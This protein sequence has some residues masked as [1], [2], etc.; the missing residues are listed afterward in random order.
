MSSNGL[1]SLDYYSEH[2]AEMCRRYDDALERSGRTALV[3]GAGRPHGIF[4]D[5]QH[6]PYKANPY[7]LQWGPLSE[8]PGSALLVQ[9]GKT[10]R[11]LVHAPVDYWH[12]I[13]PVPEL[14]MQSG[15]EI[16]SLSSREEITKSLAG[17]IR[18]SSATTAFIGETLSADDSFGIEAVNPP[19]L[20]EIL[21]EYRTIKTPWEI[22]NLK[23][24]S[25]IGVQGHLAAEQCFRG[26]GSEYEIQL[27]F[28]AACNAT[29]DEMPYPAIVA[30]NE[31]AATLHYQRLDRVR[32]QNLSLLID[33][34]HAVNGYAAD[35]TRSHSDDAE[36]G[37]LIEAMHELQR[38]LCD[39]AL[40]SV[41]YRELHHAAHLAITALLIEIGVINATLEAAHEAGLSRSFFP[42]GLGHFL[43]LNVHDVGALYTR[44]QPGEKV[45]PDED[46]HLRL[47]RTLAP[48]NVLTIEPGIYFIDSLLANLKQK[49]ASA[50]INWPRVDQLRPYG[51]IRIED[52][53]Y[54]TTDGNENL[55]RRAFASFA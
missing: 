21:N 37:S 33:A 35:I 12:R 45:R 31:H 10:P 3:I 24:A 43:G 16:I 26:G 27:A 30:L 28:R 53:L 39:A 47:T 52:N 38:G 15:L 22:A 5:D 18:G 17:A 40:P 32:E 46:K 50:M 9:P 11:L 25:A 51:G 55:T 8:H 36:F 19:E 42:H 54:I 4:L 13:P 49:P 29:D 23:A 6:L 2:I 41:D 48:G 34:G 20:I 7:L 1:N 44:R 14:L